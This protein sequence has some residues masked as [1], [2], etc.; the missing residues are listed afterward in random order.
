MQEQK[1]EEQKQKKKKVWD[2]SPIEPERW[3]RDHL[4]TLLYIESVCINNNGKPVAAKMRQTPGQPS[5]GWDLNGVYHIA[6]PSPDPQGY[7]T[8]LADGTEIWGHDDYDCAA[9]MVEAGILRWEGTGISPVFALTD[10]G[11]YV[12]G[13]LNEHRGKTKSSAGFVV[14]AKAE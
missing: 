14:P 6:P 1:Q 11:W 5:R 12:C 9:D 13:K 3:G 7:P 10:Y 8:R 2:R 4:S